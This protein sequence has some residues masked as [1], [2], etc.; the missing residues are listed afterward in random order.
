MGHCREVARHS[1]PQRGPTSDTGL[2]GGRQ[3]QARPHVGGSFWVLQ[4]GPA[5]APRPGRWAQRRTGTTADADPAARLAKHAAGSSW[6][7]ARSRRQRLCR[8]RLLALGHHLDYRLPAAQMAPEI[9]PR[10]PAERRGSRRG[11][12]RSRRRAAASTPVIQRWAPPPW[13]SARRAPRRIH[14]AR[15]L[16]REAACA[17]TVRK[18]LVPGLH[19]WIRRSW[20]PARLRK[21]RNQGRRC[22]AARRLPP[23]PPERGRRRA[24]ALH[25]QRSMRR[26]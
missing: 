6:G 15:W 18:H 4:A 8:R 12:R 26:S 3:P 13:R 11:P 22:A 2:P 10:P 17:G 14:S 24:A 23:A 16:H 5:P 9:D 1:R 19:F 21:S 7:S 25:R 20:Q